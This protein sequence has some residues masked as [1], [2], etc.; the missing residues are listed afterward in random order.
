M[1]NITGD[2][3]RQG[4]GSSRAPAPPSAPRSS[5]RYFCVEIIRKRSIPNN[6]MKAVLLLSLLVLF[7]ACAHEPGEENTP[8]PGP[9]KADIKARE[10]FASTLPKPKDR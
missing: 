3:R 7:S 8:N 6:S 9:T 5:S 10:D 2:L 4:E 1:P